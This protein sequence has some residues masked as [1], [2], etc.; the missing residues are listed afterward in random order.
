MK[1][2]LNLP[3]T[4]EIFRCAHIYALPLAE[5][6]ALSDA[7]YGFASR[8]E[9]AEWLQQHPQPAAPSVAFTEVQSV[10]KEDAIT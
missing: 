5:I 8:E 2:D 6:E 3:H 4:A 10:H 9:F 1:R 7:L